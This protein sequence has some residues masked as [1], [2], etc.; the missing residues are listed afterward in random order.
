MTA[1]KIS[2]LRLRQL[3]KEEIEQ[4]NS[5]NE[6]VDH[7]GINSIV[8][9]ASKLL[10][11]VEGFKEKAPPAA[12]NALT[13]HLAEVEKMLE[14]MVS[15]PG[16]YVPTPK[17]EP[18]TVSLRA[19]KTEGRLKESRHKLDQVLEDRIRSC[20]EELEQTRVIN[21]IVSSVGGQGFTFNVVLDDGT[22]HEYRIPSFRSNM[23]SS[24]IL[25]ELEMGRIR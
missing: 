25:D 15:S 20:I 9:V 12:I 8:T 14:N 10:A 23:S 22:E 4:N 17:K 18:K 16:S 2:L 6:A 1:P 5:V 24:D 13:P 7:K 19:T 21:F 11:A 3:V